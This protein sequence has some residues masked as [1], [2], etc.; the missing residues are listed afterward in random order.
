MAEALIPVL[1][2]VGFIALVVYSVAL[3]RKGIRAQRNAIGSV[4][5]SLEMQKRAEVRQAESLE[6][7]RKSVELEKSILEELRKLNEKR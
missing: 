6:L 2:A 3:Q 1:L 4:G 5:E 7:Q